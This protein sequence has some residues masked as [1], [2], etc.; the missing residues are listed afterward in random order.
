MSR[1]DDI[2]AFIKAAKA[3]SYTKESITAFEERVRKREA[4][5]ERIDRRTRNFDYNFKYTI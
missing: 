3:K 2:K 4:E 5:F 1:E